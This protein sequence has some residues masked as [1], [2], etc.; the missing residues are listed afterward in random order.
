MGVK[1]SV[2]MLCSNGFSVLLRLTAGWNKVQAPQN[3]F[4]RPTAKP[5]LRAAWHAAILSIYRNR[6]PFQLET[7]NH[8]ANV[9]V[10]PLHSPAALT[11]LTLSSTMSEEPRKRSR[12]D[13]TEPEPARKSR[14]DRRSR[15]PVREDAEARRSRSPIE[16]SGESPDG[17][18]KKSAA[19]AAAA[20]AAKINESL[21][22]RKAVQQ[23]DVPPILTRSPSTAAGAANSPS[24]DASA[25]PISDEIYQQDG[26]FIKDI[27]VNDLRNRYTLTKGSTQKMVNLTLLLS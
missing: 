23:V 6:I 20:A 12:F 18:A 2:V 21:Q 3:E 1:W 16:R 11:S 24:Q 9:V 27:D 17:A 22:A 13:Q 5:A 25:A 19:A 4:E 7:S 8:H 14:F 10:L 15:S 26:D